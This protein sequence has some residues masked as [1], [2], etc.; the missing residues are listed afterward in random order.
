MQRLREVLWGERELLGR[1]ERE[2]RQA[3]R[4]LYALARD[5]M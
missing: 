4:Y 1:Y 5:L 3:G 2:L